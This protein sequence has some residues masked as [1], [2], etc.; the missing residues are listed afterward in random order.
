M[1][2]RQP[3]RF[4]LADDP[5]SGKTIMAGLLIKELMAREDVRR[6]LVVCPGNLDEQWQEEMQSRFQLHFEIMTREK[7]GN[8]RCQKLVR[9][10]RSGHRP[11]GH[12]QQKRR[13]TRPVGCSRCRMGSCRVR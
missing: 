5:G 8:G 12:A 1:L 9:R 11:L 4:M 7:A 2:P 13:R 10:K 6:C 3:L